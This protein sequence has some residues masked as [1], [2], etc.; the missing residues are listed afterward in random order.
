MAA[1]TRQSCSHAV[2][3]RCRLVTITAA[4]SHA[5]TRSLEPP[6]SCWSVQHTSHT[7]TLRSG[8]RMIKLIF[9]DSAIWALPLPASS[10]KDDFISSSCHHF[11]AYLENKMNTNQRAFFSTR[12]KQLD[13][14]D[15]EGSAVLSAVCVLHPTA[16]TLSE[17]TNILY[18]LALVILTLFSLVD[19]ITEGS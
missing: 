1:H 5:L 19:T 7:A 3:Q 11:K 15:G 13:V 2:M 14:S 10:F 8:P 12:R 9:I 17:L 18:L 16:H 4:T 6:D